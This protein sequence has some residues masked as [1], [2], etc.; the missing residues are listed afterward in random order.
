MRQ[1]LRLPGVVAAGVIIGVLASG[2]ASAQD[3]KSSAGARELAQ[4]LAGKKIDAIAVRSPDAP[5]VFVAALHFPGQ[6]IV[7]SAK[8]PAPPLLNER[9]ARR[10]YRD[11]YVEL[12][13]ASAP[14]T[15]IM[16]TDIGADGVRAKPA[17]RGD[18]ADSRDIATT[19]VRFDGNW[20]EDK[21]SEADYMKAFGEADEHYATIVAW[22]LTEAKK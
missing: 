12:N 17:K 21:M 13:A 15:R 8:Y 1:A 7:V 19:S 11:V 2:P 4:V 14:E 20:R 22:L 10:E 6:L 9:L 3:T 16:I 5:D 18:A